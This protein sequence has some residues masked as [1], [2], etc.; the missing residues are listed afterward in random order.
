MN[1]KSVF[2]VANCGGAASGGA[3]G[4]CMTRGDKKIGNA[5]RGLTY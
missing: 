3:A 2:N 4:R 5:Q 1:I